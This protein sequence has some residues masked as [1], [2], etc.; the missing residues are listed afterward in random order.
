MFDHQKASIPPEY[1]GFPRRR[2]NRRTL[3][4]VIVHRSTYNLTMDEEKASFFNMR[5]L[6]LPKIF[7]LLFYLPPTSF[8]I[9]TS[10]VY[11]QDVDEGRFFSL[12]TG[13]SGNTVFRA[14]PSLIR[15]PIRNMLTK[16]FP[17]R[18]LAPKGGAYSPAPCSFLTMKLNFEKH[19]IS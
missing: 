3:Q 17:K 10:V 1:V 19:E 2:A 9:L 13:R 12:S 7:L 11:N 8:P 14:Y 18:S 5:T 6:G 4:V 16:K 15:I